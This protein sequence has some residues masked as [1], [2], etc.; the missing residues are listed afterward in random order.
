MVRM[1]LALSPLLVLVSVFLGAPLIALEPGIEYPP[2][3][4]QI[5]SSEAN[6]VG[7][8]SKVAIRRC[9]DALEFPSIWHYSAERQDI[10]SS[11]AELIACTSKNPNLRYVNIQPLCKRYQ[12][13]N[14]YYRDV[15]TLENAPVISEIV[16]YSRTSVTLEINVPGANPDAPVKY[17]EVA[18]FSNGSISKRL[19]ESGISKSITI[20]MLSPGTVY[21]FQ[22]KA[23]SIDSTSP[24]SLISKEV[25]TLP[26]APD[27]PKF[28]LSSNEETG[29]VDVELIGFTI[30]QLGGPVDGY[31]ITP[32]ISVESGLTFDTLTGAF[33]GIPLES[34][35]TTSYLITGTNESGSHTETFTL[36]VEE[37]VPAGPAT[38][39]LLIFG[40]FSALSLGA[41]AIRQKK[42]SQ[43]IRL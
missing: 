10:S 37:P 18:I 25:K 30:A 35:T 20:D 4:I 19:V 11:R 7:S 38:L 41:I 15:K 42:V 22:V 27:K 5:C 2:K 40:A 32:A 34:M 26:P 13:T 12:K 8:V 16:T 29:T 23:I 31:S 28:T 24:E 3:K 21:R 33:G 6:F 17:F 14:F 9:L 36:T 1:R 39:S 43:F